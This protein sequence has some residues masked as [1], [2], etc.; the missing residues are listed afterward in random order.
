MS[1]PDWFCPLPL[2][3][4]DTYGELTI[5]GLSLHGPAWC[6][7]DLSPLYDSPEFRGDNILVERLDGK[8]ARPVVTDETDYSLRLMF[9]GYSDQAGVPWG[10]PAGGVLANRQA[11]HDTYVAPIRSGTASLPAT[12]EI[13]D[14]DDPNA[15]IT[16]L[17]DVQPLKL[18]GWTLLP[19]AYARGVLELR[20]PVPELVAGGGEGE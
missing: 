8:V 6:A 3:C 11:F 13:P 15:T 20:V 16:Y 12:L 5:D 7:W 9:S 18:S 4:G 1:A 10:A 2:N 14:P 17:F 19:N